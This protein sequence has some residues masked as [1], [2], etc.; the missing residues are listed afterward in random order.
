M[1]DENKTITVKASEL[2]KSLGLKERLYKP[3]DGPDAGKEDPSKVVIKGQK[4]FSGIG[5][6]HSTHALEKFIGLTGLVP[7]GE[8]IKGKV[9][10]IGVF[11]RAAY[12]A[13]TAQ[14]LPKPEPVAVL[15]DEHV[16]DDENESDEDDD[17]EGDEDDDKDGEESGDNEALREHVLEELSAKHGPL[18]AVTE[19]ESSEVVSRLG[20]IYVYL[21]SEMEGE[22]D[23]VDAPRTWAMMK[24]LRETLEK[25]AGK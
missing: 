16:P 15:D 19:P 14:V 1:S 18:V 12:D 23:D 24:V 6:T 22:L 13:A 3:T 5:S 8:V 4:P 25:L 10:W 2:L 20:S 9:Y 7:I 21:R 17:S 11:N